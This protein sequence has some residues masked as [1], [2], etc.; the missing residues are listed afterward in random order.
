MDL[1]ELLKKRNLREL[2]SLSRSYGI[3]LW[4]DIR[5]EDV[6]SINTAFSDIG[7]R[8]PSHYLDELELTEE[9]F[10]EWYQDIPEEGK[11]E[12]RNYHENR[13]KIARLL[14]R[15]REEKENLCFRLS[16][17]IPDPENMKDHY[18]ES[19]DE[20]VG[21]MWKS[22]RLHAAENDRRTNTEE[23]FLVV[24]PKTDEQ[25]AAKSLYKSGMAAIEQDLDEAEDR[26]IIREIYIPEEIRDVF[27]SVDRPEAD[28]ARRTSRLIRDCGYLA[29]H[30]YEGAPL[31]VV[32]EMYCGAAEEAGLQKLDQ[33]RFLKEI[34]TQ[35][36]NPYPLYILF[37]YKGK[38]YLV[39]PYVQEEMKDLQEDT[40]E[41]AETFFTWCV[42]E[43]EKAGRDY[44]IPGLQ[45]IKEYLE[46]G[47][48]PSR[49]PYG[50]LLDF[51]KGYYQ[52]EH[53]VNN[54]GSNMFGMFWEDDLNEKDEYDEFGENSRIRHYTMDDADEEMNEVLSE[55]MMGMTF[56]NGVEEAVR[57]LEEHGIMDSIREEFRTQIPEMLKSCWKETNKPELCGYT[58]ADR[59]L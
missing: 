44:Y 4:E 5:E 53:Y 21:L 31:N 19:S 35:E 42:S 6:K 55:I 10:E 14:I 59:N 18:H 58:E 38:E 49:K 23:S 37:D 30:Y 15:L 9:S 24:D 25:R 27:Q 22:C 56:G 46:W 1:L 54:I 32:Y 28:F 26:V 36:D 34:R 12:F 11:K 2:W 17:A 51:L 41:E 43:A 48:W 20:W 13:R 50:E 7:N 39:Q 52:D 8:K 29:V 40:D 33:E 57:V 16:K 47:F 45:E 3:P